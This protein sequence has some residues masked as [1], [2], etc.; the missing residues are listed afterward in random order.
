LLESCLALLES[1]IPEAHLLGIVREPSG[2][3]LDG[4]APSN[5]FR[6]ADDR[7]IVIAAN[8]DTL[9]A[10]LCERMGRREL[11]ADK[12]FDTHQA[13]AEHQVEIESIVAEW[14]AMLPAQEIEE[15]L[16]RDGVVCGPV[17]TVADALQNEQLRSRNAFAVH[18]DPELGDFLAPGVMPKL[19]RTP[20]SV[21]WTG[22][23]KPGA[24][25]DDVY[26]G[27]LGFDAKERARLRQ[28]GLI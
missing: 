2:S 17:N 27:L 19:S 14:A 6:T 1:A 4:L 22:A 7:W 9:F 10:R 26:G 23:W 8:Q 15:L 18:E 12:R 5:I 16:N 25:N 3:R 20:G 24:D 13:R 28:E 11:I 21:R